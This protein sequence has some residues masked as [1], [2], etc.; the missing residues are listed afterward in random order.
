MERLFRNT[1]NEDLDGGNRGLDDGQI[2][3]NDLG[4][5]GDGDMMGN[6]DGRNESKFD[7]I[8]ATR[9]IYPGRPKQTNKPFISFL[10]ICA[11][12]KPEISVT[13]TGFD[14]SFNNRRV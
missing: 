8:V 12:S 6:I 10:S 4:T 9:S 13:K 3:H 7:S 11:T 14:N 5:G 1:Y 2:H